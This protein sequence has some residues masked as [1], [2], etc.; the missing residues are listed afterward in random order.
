MALEAERNLEKNALRGADLVANKI[1]AQSVF[2]RAMSSWRLTERQI[3]ALI[4]QGDEQSHRSRRSLLIF[5]DKLRPH[6]RLIFDRIFQSLEVFLLCRQIFQ[7]DGVASLW[8]K[9]PSEEASF[10][11]LTPLTWMIHG[12]SAGIK[13]VR[14]YLQTVSGKDLQ[15]YYFEGKRIGEHGEHLSG[16]IVQGTPV[17]LS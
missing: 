10:C 12:G 7:N 4:W 14:D 1:K 9:S 13:Q 3:T 15:N 11:N 5:D 6:E 2:F 17:V 16:P 8:V